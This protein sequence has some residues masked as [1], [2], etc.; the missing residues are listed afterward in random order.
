MREK[1][2]LKASSA[3]TEVQAQKIVTRELSPNPSIC[4]STDNYAADYSND[5]KQSL[6]QQLQIQ[7][8]SGSNQTTVSTDK[9]KKPPT[10]RPQDLKRCL[11]CQKFLSFNHIKFKFPES[12]AKTYHDWRKAAKLSQSFVIRSHH[13][14]CIK[15]FRSQDIRPSILN[16]SRSCIVADA[17][18]VPIST[19]AADPAAN[20]LDQKLRK[21]QEPSPIRMT[22]YSERKL[23]F[24]T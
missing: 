4:S 23:I 10:L 22:K 14:I 15:H 20:V 16:A 5:N 1:H 2:M 12:D 11:M 7:I 21:L 8:L 19:D 9:P 3:Q 13:C 18:P 17:I 6:H 24:K